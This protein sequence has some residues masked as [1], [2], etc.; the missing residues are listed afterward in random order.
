MPGGA[1]A[2]DARRRGSG[3]GQAR[4]WR[5]P[6]KRRRP[7]TEVEDA[8]R[9]LGDCVETDLRSGGQSFRRRDGFVMEEAARLTR[10][11]PPGGG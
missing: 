9:R 3:G 2:E 8:R 4:R 1:E 6:G 7:S 5:M 10:R 11:R